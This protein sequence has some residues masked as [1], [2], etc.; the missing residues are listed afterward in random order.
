MSNRDADASYVMV[1]LYPRFIVGTVYISKANASLAV[2]ELKVIRGKLDPTGY[3]VFRLDCSLVKSN[4]VADCVR[5]TRCRGGQS[6]VL[7]L[8]RDL[9]IRNINCGDLLPGVCENNCVKFPDTT[10]V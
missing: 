7:R 8:V 4:A 9:G 6:C 1:V 2:V 5:E 3:M 10:E